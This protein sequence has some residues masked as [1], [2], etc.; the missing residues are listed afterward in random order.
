MKEFV[1]LCPKPSYLKDNNDESKKAISKKNCVIKNLKFQDFKN[2]LKFSQI[3]NK[4]NYL[5]KKGI[6][7][8]SL[9]ED[10]TEFIK[11]RLL[12]KAQQRF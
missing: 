3:I 1:G 5:E 8:D 4:V 6:N 2:C 12:L 11:N 10:K 9:K 7:I